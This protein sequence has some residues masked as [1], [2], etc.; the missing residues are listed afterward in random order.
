M[1]DAVGWFDA[2]D[3]EVLSTVALRILGPGSVIR[4]LV[5]EPCGQLGSLS[6]LARIRVSG[7]DMAGVAQ[8]LSLILKREPADAAAV[9][10]TA[11]L[12]ALSREQQFYSALPEVANAVSLRVWHSDYSSGQMRIVLDDAGPQRLPTQLD[13]CPLDVALQVMSLLAELH[14]SP[15]SAVRPSKLPAW[16]DPGTALL[17]EMYLQ[18][19]PLFEETYADMLPAEGLRL[20]RSFA[21]NMLR[22]LEEWSTRNARTVVHGDARL[23]NV[24][25]LPDG[26]ARLIDWQMAGWAE[27]AFDV[28]HFIAGSLT[29]DERRRT[30]SDLIDRY[31]SEL[32]SR[33]SGA[34]GRVECED[35]IRRTL[36]M[37]LPL[38]II[39]GVAPTRD[40][41]TRTSRIAVLTR[42]FTALKDYSCDEFVGG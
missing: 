4:N 27:G 30:E 11:M 20:A 18:R 42:Y 41:A 8:E 38:N 9:G 33:G 40:E 31:F 3:S 28:A 22:M 24:V 13:G 2:Q 39:F 19:L 5:A 10:V 15:D 12:D 34:L 7:A 17:A 37:V 1:S 29:V 32:K 25:L 36:L 23:D 35:A 21:E 26:S 14:A 6:R 16:T